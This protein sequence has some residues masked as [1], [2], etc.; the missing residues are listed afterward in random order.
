MSHIRRGRQKRKSLES[1]FSK[2][3]FKILVIGDGKNDK[4]R[5]TP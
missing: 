5:I 3:W 4:N 1:E 2:F